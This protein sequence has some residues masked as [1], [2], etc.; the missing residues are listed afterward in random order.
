M[1][2]FPTSKIREIDQYTID[3]ELITS[4]DLME[5]AADALY[6]EFIRHF[7]NQYSVCILAGQGN[8]GGDAL[9]L[10]RMLLHTGYSV[11]VILIHPETLSP[12]CKINRKRLLD[13]FPNTLTEFKK[14]FYPP[15]I[16]K[17]K[18]IIDGLFG[19]GLS[20]PLTGIFAQAV[21]W[22]NQTG[23]SVVS[24]DIPSGLNGEI[25]DISN[26]SI[27]VKAKLTLSLQFPKLA[28]FLP[29][30]ELYIGH[31]KILDIGLHPQKIKLIQSNLF[32]LEEKEIADSLKKRSKFGH[33]GIFG[34]AFIVAGS[35]DMAGAAILSGMAAL[36]SGT[37]LVTVH[38]CAANRIIVQT[39]IPEVIFQSDESTDFISNVE[40]SE[41]LNS[42]AI[43]PGI[44]LH[45]ET[46]KMIHN[47]LKKLEKPCI[48]DADALN[49][50]SR[51][52]DLL[53][54]IPKNSILSPHPKEFERLFGKCNSTYERITKASEMAQQFGFIII[55]KGAYSL[56]ALPN[57]NLIFNSTGNSGM[58]TGGSG[59]VLTGI[60]AGLMAQGYTP[61]ETATMGIFIHGCSGDLALEQQS[62]ESLIAGDIIKMIGKV[63]DT[64]RNS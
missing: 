59:D 18:I 12:D 28:F 11:S 62:E 32:Y 8:N 3:H 44:G 37:G 16:T 41:S 40:I 49:I 48:L 17:K 58:A 21:N 4:I 38:S 54:L 31:W 42:I 29:E 45:P 20:R 15:E 52:K 47:L 9:A 7:P 1:K 46:A 25:N 10:A 26:K 60:L 63:F 33:K 14:V 39:A 61:E 64:F 27:I 22:I 2:F 53:L 43:G 55:L 6:W 57:G 5:R 30:N 24:I 19:S 50:I 13:D 36:R 51:N 23:C 56:V 35:L 34:H